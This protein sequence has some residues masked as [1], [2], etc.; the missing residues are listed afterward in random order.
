MKK[1]SQKELI[2]HIKCSHVLVQ[3][4]KLAGEIVN[5]GLLKRPKSRL[6]SEQHPRVPWPRYSRK[7]TFQH[8]RPRPFCTS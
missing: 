1:S 4:A 8:S 3:C 7:L 6:E 2:K 5:V